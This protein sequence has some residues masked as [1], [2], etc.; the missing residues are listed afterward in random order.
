LVD[1]AMMR[2]LSRRL[3]DGGVRRVCADCYARITLL[4]KA[5]QGALAK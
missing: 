5:V 3:T 4:R 1:A 2:P